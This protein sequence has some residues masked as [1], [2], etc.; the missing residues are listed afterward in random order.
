MD[1]P[2]PESTKSAS[3]I[4]SD[5]SSRHKR[6]SSHSKHRK[7][8]HHHHHHAD[9]SDDSPLQRFIDVLAKLPA[10]ASLAPKVVQ[11]LAM[12]LYAV[13]FAI[14]PAHWIKEVCLDLEGARQLAAACS[15]FPMA[16]AS[17]TVIYEPLSGRVMSVNKHV[18]QSRLLAQLDE[19]FDAPDQWLYVASRA[20]TLPLSYTPAAYSSIKPATAAS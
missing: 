11:T 16:R 12:H 8:H 1:P 15:Q 5:S 20:V 3:S 14:R 18:T 6:H 13:A 17:V 2:R 9:H 10:L 4:K 7:H 19:G